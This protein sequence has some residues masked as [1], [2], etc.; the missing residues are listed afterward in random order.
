MFDVEIVHDDRTGSSSLVDLMAAVR[1]CKLEKLLEA[2]GSAEA[3]GVS[4]AL[5]ALHNEVDDLRHEL[6]EVR[7]DSPTSPLV[8][9]S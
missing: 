6:G 1:S 2:A 9:G 3:G 8:L 4:Q 5:D 7:A